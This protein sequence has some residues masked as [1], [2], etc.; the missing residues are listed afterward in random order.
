MDFDKLMRL[1]TQAATLVTEVKENIDQAK[2]ALSADELGKL[3]EI[4]AAATADAKEVGLELDAALRAA[5]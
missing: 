3:Q 2:A 4:M 1:A 5:S